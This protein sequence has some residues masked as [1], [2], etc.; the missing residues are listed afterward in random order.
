MFF[1]PGGRYHDSQNQYHS[2]LETPGYSKEFKKESKSCFRHLIFEKAQ[3]S[4]FDT[5]GNFGTVGPIIPEDSFN[6]F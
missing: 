6:I 3:K 5:V 4:K 1:V 2:S